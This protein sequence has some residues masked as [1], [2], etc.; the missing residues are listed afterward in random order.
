MTTKIFFNF[1]TMVVGLNVA[2][3]ASAIT[4]ADTSTNNLNHT[5]W[6]L[7]T[8]NN[9]AVIPNVLIT[10]NFEDGNIAGTDGCNRYHTAY[11]LNANQLSINKNIAST[12]MACPEP[13]T[14]QASIYMTALIETV[15]YKI[16]GQQLIL[17]NASGKALISFAQQSGGQ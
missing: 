12:R 15:S 10:L 4:S 3:C 13:I 16:E 9:Q 5:S 1:L 6:V 17:R 14:Q 11:T 2:S 8:L 7:A